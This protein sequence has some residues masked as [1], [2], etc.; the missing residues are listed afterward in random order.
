[1]IRVFVDYFINKIKSDKSV[2]FVK[3]GNEISCRLVLGVLVLF[4]FWMFY[5]ILSL[6]L[7]SLYLICF[8]LINIYL[9]ECKIIDLFWKFN[10]K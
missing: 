5:V 10:C 4:N 6:Y 2:F 9:Y 7:I 8:Y 3:W 1:M